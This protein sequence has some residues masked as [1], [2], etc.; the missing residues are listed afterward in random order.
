MDNKLYLNIENE[1]DNEIK[2]EKIMI[3]DLKQLG[4]SESTLQQEVYLRN[5]Y[6]DDFIDIENNQESLIDDSKKVISRI[7]INEIE[8]M[9]NVKE[10]MDKM[11]ETEFN[12]NL[13]FV[14]IKIREE[15]DD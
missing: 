2:K 1:F 4:F 12:K 9:S 10:L 14:M 11:K 15:D 5:I 8:K 7:S 3:E 13:N 6:G